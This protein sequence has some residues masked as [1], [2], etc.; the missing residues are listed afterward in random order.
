MGS[1]ETRLALEVAAW[2]E[3]EDRW[4][5]MLQLSDLIEEQGEGDWQP[6]AAGYR[7]CGL[8][9]RAPV[10]RGLTKL[11]PWAWY[12]QYNEPLTVNEQLKYK[13]LSIAELPAWMIGCMLIDSGRKTPLNGHAQVVLFKTREEAVAAAGALVTKLKALVVEGVGIDSWN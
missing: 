6:L 11:K 7:W 1:N 12:A 13:R 2:E 5:A 8:V 3:G 10:T 4:D 9:K